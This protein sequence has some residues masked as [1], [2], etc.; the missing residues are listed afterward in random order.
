MPALFSP[1]VLTGSGAADF[2]LTFCPALAE[3]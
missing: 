1:L 2:G 3:T